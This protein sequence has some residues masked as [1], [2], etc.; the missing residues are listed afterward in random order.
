MLSVGMESCVKLMLILVSVRVNV[1]VD[2]RTAVV[3]LALAEDCS[4]VPYHVLSVCLY[5]I[6]CRELPP[7]SPKAVRKAMCHSAME[8]LLKCRIV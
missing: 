5:S 4:V 6:T 1:F 3:C 7:E 8:R 2:R